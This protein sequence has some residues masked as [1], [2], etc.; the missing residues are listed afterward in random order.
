ML[1]QDLDLP[2]TLAIGLIFLAWA[3][4]AP[5]L[6]AFGRGTL[7]AQLHV[8]RRRWM[9]LSSSRVNPTFDAVLLGHI[10]NAVAFFGSATLIV[11]AGL[12]GALVNV[13]NIHAMVGQLHFVALTSLPLFALKLAVVAFCVGLSFFSLTYALRKLTYTLALAGGLTEGEAR[14]AGAEL[15]EHTATVLTEAVKSFNNG[16]RGYYFALAA[17]CLFAGPYV[18]MLVTLGVM[19][20]LFWR[21]TRSSTALAIGRYVDALEREDDVHG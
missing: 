4:Y 2:T 6:G 7:N 17:L 15:V 16:I 12:L 13:V 18:S 20:L 9:R 1:P 21:Q 11:L 5:L 14:G 19:I 10:I 8:V 3:A